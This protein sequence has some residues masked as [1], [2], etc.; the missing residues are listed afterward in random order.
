MGD[1]PR[2]ERSALLHMK[3]ELLQ[4]AKIT[5]SSE[6]KFADHACSNPLKKSIY[7]KRGDLGIC[8]SLHNL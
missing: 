4:L 1:S 6:V 3:N 5:A 8:S 7:L 2:S